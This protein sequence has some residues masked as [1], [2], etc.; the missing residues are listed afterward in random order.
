M[1]LNKNVRDAIY[2][3]LAADTTITATVSCF[4]KGGAGESRGIFP[5]VDISEISYTNEAQTTG[6]QG[7]D[8]KTFTINIYAG[9]KSHAYSKAQDDLFDLLDAIYDVCRVNNFGVFR[10]PATVENVDTATST[11]GAGFVWM[12]RVILSGKVRV[13][14]NA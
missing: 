7:Y 14:R 11:D 8:I 9:T 1:G 3:A 4:T 2:N 12:G 6:R 10:D 5:F 13:Q